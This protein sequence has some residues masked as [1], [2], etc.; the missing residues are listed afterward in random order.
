[1]FEEPY[2]DDGGIAE[3]AFKAPFGDLMHPHAI[4]KRNLRTSERPLGSAGMVPV[5]TR[6]FTPPLPASTRV[7]PEWRYL[8]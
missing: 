7:T 5:A 8:V 3:A 1:M 2:A 6:R 4:A